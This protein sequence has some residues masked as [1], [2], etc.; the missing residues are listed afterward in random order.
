MDFRLFPNTNNINPSIIK[1]I[2]ITVSIIDINL[3]YITDFS[4]SP[5][6]LYTECSPFINANSPFPADHNVNIIDIEIVPIDFEYTSLI[7]PKTNSFILD[8]TILAI[9]SNNVCWSIFVY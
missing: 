8:G 1:T 5:F 2:N 6:I 7:I 3:K 9:T 4:F